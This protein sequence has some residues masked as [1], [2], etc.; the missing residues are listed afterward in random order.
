MK[1]KDFCEIDPVGARLQM[2]IKEMLLYIGEDPNREGLIKTPERI[3]R[4][5]EELYSGYREDPGK[6]LGTTFKSESSEMII[7]REIDLFS[8]CEHHILPIVGVCHIGYIPK[9]R[10]VGISKLARL[11][12]IYSRRLQIQERLTRQIADA[13]MRYLQPLGCMVVID[14][15]HH[16]MRMRGVSKQN[17]VMVTQA[18]RGIFD[19]QTVRSE[20]L[21]A[22]K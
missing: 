2:S 1:E 3:V 14:A 15:V 10:I 9:D 22:I 21:Q 19:S 4:S 5:W 16:C 8:N 11:V 12:N 17:S 6:V 18:V 20:F 7:L 13:I